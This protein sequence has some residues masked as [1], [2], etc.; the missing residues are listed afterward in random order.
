M[1]RDSLVRRKLTLILVSFGICMLSASA[2]C[3]ADKTKSASGGDELV[4]VFDFES[5]RGMYKDIA[6]HLTDS[7]RT[8][9]AKTGKYRVMEKSDMEQMLG[10]HAFHMTR[11]MVVEY[12]IEAG[13]TLKVRTVI[14]GFV[15]KRD[16]LYYVKLSRINTETENVEFIIEDK[17]TG[18]KE[19]LAGLS[20][21]MLPKLLGEV[22]VA[23]LRPARPENRRFV[24]RKLSILDE[25]SGLEWVRDADCT[26]IT[27]TWDDAN[28]YIGQFNSQNYAGNRDWRLPKKSE[29]ETIIDYAKQEGVAKNINEAI[30]R[31]GFKNMKAEYYWSATSDEKMVGL[32]WVMDM[33][34]GTMSTAGKSGNFYLWLVR[35]P[36]KP[37]SAPSQK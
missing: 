22:R 19:E 29:F 12:A 37:V 20:A 13:R 36:A 25:A 14:I 3:S 26:P 23:R 6:A 33:Y 9:L 4:V 21:T 35:G 8:E 5:E 27:M 34:S 10:R 31:L 16:D 18:G 32:I 2:V 30:A 15:S 24:V 7:I 28:E 17:C 1:F 11:D